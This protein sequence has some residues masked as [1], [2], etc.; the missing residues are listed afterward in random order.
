M[1]TK[2]NGSDT[3]Q[4]AS[5]DA[6]QEGEFAIQRIYIKD[7][8]FETPNTP[9]IFREQWEPAVTVDLNVNT[10]KLEDTIYEVKLVITVKVLCKEKTAFLAE[11]H[12]AGIFS[13][14]GYPVEYINRALG[15]SCPTI[16]FPYAREAIS[17]LVTRGGFP[18]LYLAPINFDAIYQ[19]QLIKQ[20]QQAEATTEDSGTTTTRM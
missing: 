20:K 8:S 6:K 15:S 19:Q 4:Q 12:Q 17:D 11:I 13:I 10:E 18:P 2:L 7:L 5:P 14:K 1:T 9:Q 16:L 3:Q